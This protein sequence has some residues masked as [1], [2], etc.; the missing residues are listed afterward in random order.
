MVIVPPKATGLQSTRARERNRRLLH[1]RR[2]RLLDRIAPRPEPE[3][4][5]P[6]ITASNI[7]YE[8]GERVQGLRPAASAPCS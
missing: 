8:L 1:R 2:Q 4:K 5:A 6:M 7:H 3:R